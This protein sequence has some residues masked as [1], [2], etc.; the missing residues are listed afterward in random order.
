MPHQQTFYDR[1][2]TGTFGFRAMFN[3][4]DFNEKRRA[5]LANYLAQLA[6]QLQSLVAR[7]AFIS[8]FGGL[9]GQCRVEEHFTPRLGCQR[10]SNGCSRQQL[11]LTHRPT[12]SQQWL[13]QRPTP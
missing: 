1:A 10:C 2:T 9:C 8:E 5:G 13:L 12:L 11:R 4:G 7:F 6:Q 3:I